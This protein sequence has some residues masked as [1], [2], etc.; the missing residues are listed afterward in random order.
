[1][2]WLYLSLFSA[3]LFACLN[4]LSRVVS[5]DSKN[6]RALTLAFNLVCIS[7]AIIL[8]LV[9]GSYKKVVLPTQNEAWIFFIIAA[10]AYGM[11]ERLRF[12]ATKNL[13]ASIYSIIGN[14]SVVMAFIISL[15]LYKEVLTVSKFIG[16]IFILTSLLLVIEVKKS[17]ISTKGLLLGIITSI[18]IGIGW[19]LDKKGAN[20]FN[21]ETYNIL[22]WT[23]PFIVIYFPGIDLKEVK[24]E[25]KKFSWKIVL[26]AFFNFVGYYLTLKAYVLA[27]ATK[28]IPIIQ[29]STLITVITGVFLLKE[30]SNLGRKILAGI[31]AV[32]GVFLLR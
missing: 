32:A 25:F 17:K 24:R 28:I 12:Y 4:I 29:L 10:F 15:F 13:D 1:M 23:L 20:Y 3:F 22:G 8:F 19:S 30:R 9:T 16:F 2:T 11:F 6:P 26:L 27:E 21:P 18:L 14:I 5:V 31:I 7:M